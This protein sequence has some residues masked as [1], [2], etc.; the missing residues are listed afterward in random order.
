M[1]NSKSKHREMLMKVHGHKYKRHFTNEGYYCFYCG[2]P[3]QCL[4]H[5]PPLSMM[6]VLSKEKIKKDRIPRALVPCCNEC[7]GALGDRQLLSVM[8]RLLYLESYYD[9]Y[10]KRCRALWTD[11][12]I[13]ELGSSLK[14]YVRHRQDKLHRYVDKIRHL[15]LRQI[16]T[17][18]FPVYET[19]ETIEE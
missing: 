12:E 9:A 7:N 2:D 16:K 19:D 18:T 11:E 6:D 3:G 5:V 10:L 4:D 15:Q 1:K 13:D 14:E 8:D 17:E